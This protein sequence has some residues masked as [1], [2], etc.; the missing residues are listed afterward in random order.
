M[1]AEQHRDVH[2]ENA[3]STAPA[4][5]WTVGPAGDGALIRR[6]TRRSRRRGATLCILAASEPEHAGRLRANVESS[7]PHRLSQVNP[8]LGHTGKTAGHDRGRHTNRS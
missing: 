8:S 2:T 7:A 4:E 1:S 6:R 5:T 3:P